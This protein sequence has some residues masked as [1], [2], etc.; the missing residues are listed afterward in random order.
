ME[1]VRKEVRVAMRARWV[2]RRLTLAGGGAV[3]IFE[4]SFE[5]LYHRA[6]GRLWVKGGG[7][8]DVVAC[9]SGEAIKGVLSHMETIR[10]TLT[11]IDPPN[12]SSRSMDCTSRLSWQSED[13]RRRT[14]YPTPRK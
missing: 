12:G 8:I 10:H 4:A 11:S 7:V 6:M 2:V 9:V 13:L 5:W 1:T 3:A 14:R